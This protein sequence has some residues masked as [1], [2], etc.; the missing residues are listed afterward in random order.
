MFKKLLVV[1]IVAAGAIV[2][3][4]KVRDQRAEQELW[5]EATDDVRST[6][7]KPASAS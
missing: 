6:P 4:K 5:A 2:V 1:A 3:Q 7:P